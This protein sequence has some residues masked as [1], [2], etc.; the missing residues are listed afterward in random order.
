[1]A[2]W[3][4]QKGQAITAKARDWILTSRAYWTEDALEAQ[5]SLKWPFSETIKMP[6][7]QNAEPDGIPQ[8]PSLF[9]SLEPDFGL[10]WAAQAATNSLSAIVW[11]EQRS[12]F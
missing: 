12:V 7:R 3:V 4:A 1:L 6:S 8:R 9:L 2:A 11:S 5:R 10:R